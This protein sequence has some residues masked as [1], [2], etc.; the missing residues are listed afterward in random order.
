MLLL[1][2]NESWWIFYDFLILYAHYIIDNDYSQ[3]T[4]TRTKKKE[5]DD[6]EEEE[7]IYSCLFLFLTLNSLRGIQGVGNTLNSTARQKEDN[8][9]CKNKPKSNE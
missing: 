9:S 3:P 7:A 2:F 1:T 8:S 4:L 5:R 6:N